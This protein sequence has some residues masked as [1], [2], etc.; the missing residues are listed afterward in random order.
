M[1]EPRYW[2]IPPDVYNPLHGEFA[3]DYDPC[4]YPRP[5]GYD[6]TKVDWMRS[7][8]VNPPFHRENGIGPTAFVRKAIAEQAK[9]NSSFLAIP[10]QSYVNLLLEAGAIPRSLG[11]VR[12]LEVESKEP[13]KAPSP[14]TGFWLPA[15]NIAASREREA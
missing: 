15:R 7:N 8:W 2:L 12:W 5:D 4:P 10:T 13:T 1:S 3:F 6:G 14:I 11:R 9:G